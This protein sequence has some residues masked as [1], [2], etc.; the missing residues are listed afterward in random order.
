MTGSEVSLRLAR[1][2]DAAAIANL[3]RVE[4]EY[5]LRWRWTAERV[6]ASI[7]D[8]NVNVLVA[9]VG[10]RTVGFAIMR[11]ADDSAHLDLLAVAPPYRRMGVARRLLGWLETCA[12]VAG[13]FQVSL[14]V[15]EGNEA[16]QLFYEQLGY[17]AVARLE[18]Y[19]QNLEGAIRMTRDLSCTPPN[20]RAG[21]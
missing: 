7:R 12:K 16:A 8:P 9:R 17:R 3:S 4:I 11:Y 18:R 19:Y 2:A 10:G 13:I 15:R 6:A 21:E 14:E 1:P 20:D 5:G